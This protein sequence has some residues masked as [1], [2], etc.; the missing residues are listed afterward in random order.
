MNTDYILRFNFEYIYKID[1]I[2][3]IISNVKLHKDKCI[4]PVY[5][6]VLI[7]LT[8]LC[9]YCISKCD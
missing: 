1:I 7:L 8:L 2:S 3:F 6:F 5:K 4:L 9:K